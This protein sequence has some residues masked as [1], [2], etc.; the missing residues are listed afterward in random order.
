MPFVKEKKR[1][2]RKRKKKYNLAPLGK[3]A[4]S[5]SFVPSHKAVLKK[6]RRHMFT[7]GAENFPKF[8]GLPFDEKLSAKKH[9]LHAH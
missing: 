1:R 2:N 8:Y 3:C 7:C 9:K 5:K 6:Y 4:S